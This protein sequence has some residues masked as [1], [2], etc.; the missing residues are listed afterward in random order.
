MK[1]NMLTLRIHRKEFELIKAGTKKTEWR[2]P[3]KF[4]KKLLLK[5]GEDGLFTENFDIKEILFVNGHRPDSPRVI[6]QVERIRPIRFAE[7]IK[8]PADNFI[9]YQGQCA[10]EIRISG[11]KEVV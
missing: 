5:V 3:S 8:I 6:A 4:N 2:Q 7:D 9:G 11:V 10:I 1:T